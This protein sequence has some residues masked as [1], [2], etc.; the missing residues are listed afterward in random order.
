MVKI[1]IMNEQEMINHVIATY[2]EWIEAYNLNPYAVASYA[3]ARELKIE[4]EKT[5]MCSYVE[6]AR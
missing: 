4:R 1:P 5:E 6:H 2:S 3:L